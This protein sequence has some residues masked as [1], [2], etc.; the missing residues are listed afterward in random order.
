MITNPEENMILASVMHVIAGN[1]RGVAG[2]GIAGDI[3]KLRLD[4]FKR[5]S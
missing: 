1:S 3:M 4:T 2:G 5:A